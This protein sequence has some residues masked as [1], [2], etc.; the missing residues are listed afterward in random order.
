LF[1]DSQASE[2]TCYQFEEYIHAHLLRYALPDSIQRHRIFV[3][4]KCNELITDKQAQRRRERGYKIINCPV[5]D[6]E[7]SLLDSIDRIRKAVKSVVTEI[8]RAAD[9]QRNSDLK[10]LSAAGEMRTQG[11]RGWIGAAKS[12][13]ILHTEIITSGETKLEGE[14]I[15]EAISEAHQIHFDYA[16]QLLS[17]RDSYLHKITSESLVAAFRSEDEALSFAASLHAADREQLNIRTGI[18]SGPVNIEEMQTFNRIADYAH[19]IAGAAKAAEIWISAATKI[20][21]ASADAL[22]F[23]D[24]LDCKLKGLP[25]KHI[26]WSLAKADIEELHLQQHADD[27]IAPQLQPQTRPGVFDVFLAHH[28]QDKPQ[29]EIIAQ[30][31]RERGLV[32]WLDKEQV[33]PGRWFQD[34]IQNVIPQVKSAAIFI[35]VKGLGKWEALELRSFISQCVEASLPVIPVLLPGVNHIPKDLLFLKE[36]NWVRFADGPDDAE[37]MDNL[38][39]GV[40]GKHP[41]RGSH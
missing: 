11:I 32:P 36:L 1:F 17:K 23:S 21:L 15:S 29:V 34:V 13:V 8:D 6:S 22:N 5:C 26:L 37:A 19:R 27:Q 4:S 30:K 41:K 16:R 39:W 33:P 38:E 2:E 20:N 25:G 7:V 24:H 28:S 40:T 14:A 35:G 18:H 12:V 9:A 31:L 3:C 10:A